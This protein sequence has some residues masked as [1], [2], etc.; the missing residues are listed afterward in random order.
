MVKEQSFTITLCDN[1]VKVSIY[2]L[3]FL[4][5]IFFAPWSS[6]ALDFNKQ[7]L[8]TLLSFLGLFA[9]MLKT[10]VSGKFSLN[11]NKIHIV[12]G[13][14]FLVYLVSTVFS[15]M[16]Y[17]S[18]WGWPQPTSESLLSI[19]G[20][21]IVYFLVSNNFSK[22]EIQQLLILLVISG[23]LAVLY[24]LFQIF[25][26]YVIP[27][28]F[29]KNIA[30]NTVGQVGSLIL[31][32]V[33]LLP[34]SIVFLV[35][36]KKY[37]RLLFVVNIA[38]TFILLLLVG[39]TFIWWVVLVDSALIVILGI[40]KRNLFDG[41]WMFLPMLFLVL[42]LFFIVLNPQIKWIPQTPGEIYLSVKSNIAIDSKTLKDSPIFG[43]GPG[44]FSYNFAKYKD[45]IFNQG[46]LWNINFTTGSSK[47]LTTVATTG[48]LGFAALLVLMA[49]ALFYGVKYFI[50]SQ[51]QDKEE[52]LLI[53]G[54]VT[55]LTAESLA[56][57][58][59]NANL[60]LDFVYFTFLAMLVALIFNNE[61]TYTLKPSSLLTLITTF[62]FTLI[63]IFG[64]GFL[65]LEGQRYA[66]EARYVRA[67]KLLQKSQGE[68]GLK[69][70]E[71]AANANPA[72]DLYFRQLAQVYF[73]NMG[74]ELQN[75]KDSE[76]E[77]SKK[78]QILVSNAL[79]AS[80]IAVDLSPNNIANWSARGNVYQNLIGLVE[81]ADTEAV[82]SY[83]K[84]MELDP[85]NPYYF[86]QRGAVYYQK[87]D[88]KKAET[89]FEQALTLR[90]NYPDALY[91][92][93]LT[94]DSQNQ[95]DKAV[96]TFSK[97]L[98]LLPPDQAQNIQKILDNLKAGKQALE[99]LGPQQPPTADQPP[100]NPSDSG[101]LP[102]L[103][104]KD[105]KTNKTTET[106]K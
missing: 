68:T 70:L 86:L 97:L 46:P 64:L 7:A 5:P 12:V 28:S 54:I 81:N 1:I 105:N 99:G 69:A 85:I 52:N 90:F 24:G 91:F 16:R 72:V 43:S 40:I 34:L 39:Y 37:L 50:V 79:N 66:A 102:A 80:K 100:T 48:I 53:L 45:Q 63:F 51:S 11:V 56:Y 38:L 71:Q 103:P 58:L 29:A 2:S 30:F 49:S 35:T 60:T 65:L 36:S 4:L 33:L 106:K 67:I 78:I 13:A 101:A 26:W 96:D 98:P 61:K 10:L 32:A 89:D 41:R 31:F 57:F 19:I 8:L 83:N 73:A 17:G 14:L 27:F 76:D 77:K 62:A 87:K 84:A 75:N 95:K 42:S 44:T 15:V 9:W 59:Y 74:A 21:F 22:K 3:A 94:L 47:M 23:S 88:Y 104:A 6:D 93:G 25:G 82:T 55:A 18:V 20:I 92:L